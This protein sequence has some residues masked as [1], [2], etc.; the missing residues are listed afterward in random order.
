MI[1][2]EA[3][4]IKAN[5]DDLHTIFLLKKNVWADIIKTILG[6]SS[7]AV[8][9]ILKKWKIAIISVGQVYKSMEEQHDYQM[10]IRTTYGGRTLSMDIGKS[11]NKDGKLKCF[12]CEEYEYIA[13]NCK[14]LKKEKNT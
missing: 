10:G 8:P 14:K 2:F 11:N 7:I 9:E 6:Y 13:R 3:L 12:N 4:A 5:T 1:E